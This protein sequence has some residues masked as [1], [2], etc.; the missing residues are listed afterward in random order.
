MSAPE[1]IPLDQFLESASERLQ[2]L[3]EYSSLVQEAAPRRDQVEQLYDAA[4]WL[5]AD[6]AGARRYSGVAAPP[7]AIASD[8][9][10][11]ASLH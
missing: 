10:K 4:H 9:R 5:S 1:Q 2:F 7:Q 11:T 8:I 6:G 3:R